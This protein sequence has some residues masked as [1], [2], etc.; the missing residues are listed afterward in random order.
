M[1][2]ASTFAPSFGLRN[3]L[4]QTVLASKRPAAKHWR[5]RGIDLAPISTSHVLDCGD[6]VRLT[7]QYTPQPQSPI[8]L[9]RALVVL[10]HGWEG[11]HDSAYLVSMAC[12]LHQAGYAVFRLNLRDHGG[13]HALNQAMFHSARMSEVLGAVRAIQALDEQTRAAKLAVIG[14]SLGGNFALRVGLHGWSA[15]LQPRLS[16]GISPAIH[17]R[18]TLEAIDNGPAVFQRYFLQK[19]LLTQ[20]LK[21]EAWPGHYDFTS[22]RKLRNFIEMT[23]RFVEDYT[24]Y[25]TLEAYFERYTL[26]PSAMM[27]SPSPLAIITAGDDSVVPI[28]D[29]AGLSARGSML[30][31]EATD[32][33]GHCGFIQDWRLNTWTETRVLELFERFI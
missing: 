29:F 17:P 13:S 12:A 7:G 6:S 27:D 14:F 11:S 1:R 24:E 31:F 19:W 5:K 4:V 2:G 25:D 30:H 28:A 9:P 21:A 10:I 23:Q 8:A 32:R 20:Q 18:H 3:A 22:H 15:G 33:G 16:I 26:T